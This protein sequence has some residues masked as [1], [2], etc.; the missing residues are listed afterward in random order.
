M[1]DKVEFNALDSHQASDSTKYMTLREIE[2][3][4]RNNSVVTGIEADDSN[5][6]TM[7]YDTS[8]IYRANVLPATALN[9]QYT[10]TSSDS[11]LIRVSPNSG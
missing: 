7:D 3:Y 2:L 9:R 8:M 4:G 11:D 6:Y 1:V 5:V 10:V